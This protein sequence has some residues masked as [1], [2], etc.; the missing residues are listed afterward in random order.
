MGRVPKKSNN[1][2]EKKFTDHFTI[3]L[4]LKIPTRTF[5]KGKKRKIINM[6][7]KE[8]WLLYP[9][10]TDKYASKMVNAVQDTE[11][12][13]ELEKKLDSIDKEI[14]I[15]AFGYIYVKERSKPK[16]IKKKGYKDLNSMYTEY[17]DEVDAAITECLDRKDI[18]SRMYKL[19][20]LINGPKIK[21]QEQAAI[22]DPKTNVLIT[23]EEKIKEVSLAHNVEILTK[24][25][26]LPQYEYLIKEKQEGHNEMMRR[27]LDEDNWTLDMNFYKKV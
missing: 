14:Q 25:K 19:K 9:E 15:E 12:A 24:M 4:K 18:N 27:N 21:P 5:T 22:N 8:G 1:I 13:D 10:I 16:K 11:D 26:P 6:N 20:T 2:I 23:D 17:L 7:N 3:N